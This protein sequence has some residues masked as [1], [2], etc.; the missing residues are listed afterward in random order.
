MCTLAPPPSDPMFTIVVS[1][2]TVLM[3]IPIIMLLQFILDE[4]ARRLP[5]KDGDHAKGDLFE[6]T[7]A[8]QETQEEQEAKSA[9]TSP[10]NSPGKSG[11]QSGLAD[12]GGVIRHGLS[13][14]ES[15]GKAPPAFIEATKLS[16]TGTTNQSCS[17]CHVLFTICLILRCK[18][19][20]S[21]TM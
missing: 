6:Q 16:Y 14:N 18:V 21:Y 17:R 11:L 8:A 7:I 9:G 2:L 5:G 15:K 20:S 10:V 4:Y 12:F 1:L 19:L 13:Q 3:S